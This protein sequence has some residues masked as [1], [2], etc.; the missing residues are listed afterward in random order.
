[1]AKDQIRL[2]ISHVDS[3]PPQIAKR[4]HWDMRTWTR[5]TLPPLPFSFARPFHTPTFEYTRARDSPWA[6]DP[7]TACLFSLSIWSVSQSQTDAL[8][9]SADAHTL[10]HIHKCLRSNTPVHTSTL[11]LP[12]PPLPPPPP[13][14]LSP[15]DAHT[16]RQIRAQT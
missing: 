3:H 12:P 5:N 4:R 9:L 1:M 2:L 8:S 10:M 7:F 13:P 11:F 15:S 14:S 16:F 6:R